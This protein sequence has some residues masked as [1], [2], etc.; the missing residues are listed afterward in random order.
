MGEDPG[1]EAQAGQTAGPKYPP[2]CFSSSQTFTLPQLKSEDGPQN[3][4]TL[5]WFAL[6]DIFRLVR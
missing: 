5:G 1:D 3:P 2:L 4:Q 6:R